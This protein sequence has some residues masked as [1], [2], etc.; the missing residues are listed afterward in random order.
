VVLYTSRQQREK[1]KQINLRKVKLK[2]IFKLIV[3]ALMTTKFK[4]KS[5]SVCRYNKGTKQKKVIAYL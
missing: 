4:L 2:I 5:L 3:A 1:T